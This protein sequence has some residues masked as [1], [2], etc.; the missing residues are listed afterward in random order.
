[1]SE[2]PLQPGSAEDRVALVTGASRGIGAEIAR[3]LAR[4]GVRVTLTYTRGAAEAERVVAEIE[5]AGGRA[6]AIRADAATHE[7]PAEAVERTVAHFG[8]LDIVVNN[9]GYMD[10][11]GLPLS[12]VPAEVIDRTLHVN[13]R[14]ALLTA[15]AAARH[16]PAGGRVISIASCLGERVPGPGM[17]PYAVSKAAL[18]GLTRGLARELGERGITVNQVSPGPV[19]TDMN[20]AEGPAADFQRSLTAVGRYGTP[21]DIAE[22]VAF[23]ASPGAAFITGANLAADGGTTA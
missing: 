12:D 3:R 4:S 10:T 1:M 2:P 23:L 15:R 9:A 14:G 22:A 17:V 18:L 21:A 7:G 19:D 13:V 20:P 8:R 5:A 16:L 11:S 6:F